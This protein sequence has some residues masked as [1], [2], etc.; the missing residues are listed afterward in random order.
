MS[1]KRVTFAPETPTTNVNKTLNEDQSDV[2][3]DSTPVR[4]NIA[5]PHF[6]VKLCGQLKSVEHEF[7]DIMLHDFYMNFES[8]NPTVTVF[9]VYLGGLLVQDLLQSP[10][11]SYSYLMSSSLPSQS[12]N[13]HRSMSAR[14]SVLSTSCPTVSECGLNNDLSTSLPSYFPESPVR[15]GIPFRTLSPLRPLKYE[16][17]PS[18]P[19]VS[20]SEEGKV[21]VEERSRKAS[22]E[23]QNHKDN[24]LATINVTLVKKENEDFE[25]KYKSVS[26]VTK[27]LKKV[28]DGTNPLFSHFK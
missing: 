25:T 16:K 20:F 6:S 14:T 4:A 9:D 17:S 21:E 27:D 12:R 23:R 8:I 13:L 24:A 28:S 11:S 1:S 15:K 18:L 19:S 3:D 10:D 7:V 26:I 22:E 5:V 2:E